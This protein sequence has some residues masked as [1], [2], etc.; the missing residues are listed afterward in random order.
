MR[1]ILLYHS[2]FPSRGQC[3]GHFGQNGQKLHKNYKTN[4]LGAKQWGMGGMRQTNFLG[5]GGDPPVRSTR[6][7]PVNIHSN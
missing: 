4:I 3:V 2:G 1:K 7:S 6:R 5:S